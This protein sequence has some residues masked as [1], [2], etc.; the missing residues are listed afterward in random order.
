MAEVKNAFIK[1]KMNKD[2]DSRL[3]PPGEYRDGLNIQVSKSESEDVGALENAVGN[4]VASTSDATNPFVD[5]NA[6]TGLSGLKTIGMY[7]EESQSTLYIFLTNNSSA[8]LVYN[9]SASNFIYSYNTLTKNLIKL[10]E[11]S[12]LN[13]STVNPIY[14]INVIENLLFWTDNRNQPRKINVNVDF[15]NYITEDQISVAKYNPYQPIDLYYINPET[16]GSITAGTPLTSMQDVVSE[17]L[18]DGTTPNPFY[19]APLSQ[20]IPVNENW[21]GDPNYLKDKFVSFSYRFKFSDGEYSITAPFTQEAFIPTQDGYF[22]GTGDTSD[23]AEAFRSS[24]V[25]FMENKVNNI[26]LNIPLPVTGDYLTATLG[27]V[28]IDILYKE[29]D[30]LSIKVLDTITSFGNQNVLTYSYQSKKPYKTLPESE[31]VRVYD[32][33]PVRALGQEAIGNRIVY[34]NFQDKH[35]PPSSIDYDVIV[36]E[37]QNFSAPSNSNKAL[38]TTS[39]V[40]YPI[41]TVKQNRN[42]QVGFILSDR[43]GRQSTTI[44][45]PTT[46]STKTQVIDGISY[47]YVGSTY[48]HPYAPN[49][50]S[51]TPPLQNNINSWAGDSI[52]LVINQETIPLIK[53]KP[54]TDGWPGLW[55]GDPS[56]T[57]YNPLGWYSYKVVVKQTEQDYYNVYLPGIL[58]DYPDYKSTERTDAPDPQG[59]I[60][61]ISLISDNINKVPRDLTEVG[62]EQ[63][64]Y[65]S[66]VKL[67]GRV[68]PNFILDTTPTFNEPY[69]PGTNTM[70]VV[71]IAEQDNMFTDANRAVPPYSTIYQTDSDPYIARISQNKVGASPLPNAIGS[72]QINNLTGYGANNILLGVFETAP[73]ESLLD[74]FYETTTAGLVS[75]L[76]DAA[77][78]PTSISGWEFPWIQTEGFTSLT[79]VFEVGG[80][81]PTKVDGADPNAPIADSTVALISVTNSN[82]DDISNNWIDSNG[83]SL[84]TVIASGG[85]LPSTL[86][87]G[88][89][90]YQFQVNNPL[91]FESTAELNEFTFTFDVIDN[92]D[93][94]TTRG[95]EITVNLANV[96]PTIYGTNLDPANTPSSITVSSDRDASLP[97]VQFLA[98]NGTAKTS[99]N[100]LEII[101]D[102]NDP[103]GLLSINSNG[104]LFGDASAS[105]GYNFTVT[106]TDT[107]GAAGFQSTM[108]NIYLVFG[109]EQLNIDFGS[110]INKELSLGLTSFGVYWASTYANGGAISDGPFPGISNNESIVGNVYTNGNIG[111][112]AFENGLALPNDFNSMSPG[113]REEM[114]FST[115]FGQTNQGTFTFRNINY[116]TKFL[117][118]NVSNTDNSLK[119]GT[120]FIK[121]DFIFKSWPY[122]NTGVGSLPI[123]GASWPVYLQYRSGPGQTWSTAIDVEGQEIRFGGTQR[124]MAQPPPTSVDTFQK[125]GILQSIVNIS[126]DGAVTGEP[127]IPGTP[128]NIEL[129]TATSTA[130][131]P[132]NNYEFPSESI[133]SKVFVFGKDQGYE[134]TPDKFGEYR[135]LCRFPQ[136]S[137]GLQTDYIT[138]PSVVDPNK[139]FNSNNVYQFPN[140]GNKIDQNV[141][142]NITMG[143]FYY[144]S[145]SSTAQSYQFKATAPKISINEASLAVPNITVYA[146]EWDLKYVTQFYTS[147]ELRTADKVNFGTSGFVCYAPFQTSTSTS[148]GLYGTHNSW[149]GEQ[150][151]NINTSNNINIAYQRKW[152]ASFDADGLKVKGSAVPITANVTKSN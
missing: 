55:N 88:I 92:S 18:P 53:A 138:L 2:L 39:S 13:F 28:E 46:L 64:Q 6:I 54:T 116:V 126:D 109:Q 133:L 134:Q 44:L 122:S 113:G 87:N 93:G 148:P 81:Y 48:Y 144:P 47:T 150:G 21:P 95:A 152:V 100:R 71:A 37:K 24:I 63:T 8:K 27:I 119:T 33:V 58:N 17:L 31:T 9:P 23:E 43:Y 74:I 35:T 15:S 84:N 125:N 67:F 5:F 90:T 3:L 10:V 98:K 121:L 36:S 91:Y 60:A 86:I 69:Y 141:K 146:R 89:K 117:N 49:P 12:F 65:R 142:V 29:S 104:E 151:A 72:S 103:S 62:P 25:S 129:D 52:K 73:V 140:S 106:A 82:G 42:Y 66:D 139:Y 76:N 32:K 78:A 114:T 130:Q 108:L 19:N 120:A 132:T 70:T 101:W 97:V 26:G 16:I 137:N 20:Q 11:G 131:F 7:S 57:D 34:S 30:G 22:L 50:S 128:S 124:N 145:F 96:A 51:F 45:A 127:T 123:N 75:D 94:T 118:S 143:D 14:S 110:C 38:Y 136:G 40:E 1:S 59:T 68:T 105:G 99:D 83:T 4:I 41:H 79:P 61:H 56:S 80:F 77:A 149:N 85:A 111:R 147:P 135:L 112:L 115:D 107:N 102:I